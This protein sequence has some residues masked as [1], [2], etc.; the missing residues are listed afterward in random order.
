MGDRQLG[1]LGSSLFLLIGMGGLLSRACQEVI[2][3]PQLQVGTGWSERGSL[4]VNVA[5]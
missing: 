4:Y 2:L 5:L 3:L 1:V